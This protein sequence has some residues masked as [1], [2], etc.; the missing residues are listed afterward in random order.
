MYRALEL[1]E[2]GATAGSKTRAELDD[3]LG[4]SDLRAKIKALQ[5]FDTTG[6]AVQLNMATSI[7][8]N[9]LKAK[10]MNHTTNDHFAEAFE[11][12]QTYTPVD[13]WIERETHGMIKD[14]MGDD[15]IEDLTVALLVDAVYF[16]GSWM[17]EFDKDLN[18]DG[19]FY[20][21]DGS[22]TNATYMQSSRKM[23]ATKLS[24]LGD[25]SV[26]ALDYKN[27]EFSALF[28][29]PASDS[30]KSMQDAISG[31]NSQSL[32]KLIEETNDIQA[33]LKLPRFRL[34]FGPA[35]LKS[36]LQNMGMTTAFDNEIL[37]KFN[38][39][40][41]DKYLYIKD[42]FHG[43]SMEVNEEGTEAAASTV[44]VAT[45]RS[46]PRIQTM[47][48]VFNRPFIVVI[49]HQSSGVPL[50]IGKVEQP[51]FI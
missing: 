43:A 49:S 33:E 13:E 31:L 27:A 3:L 28:I 18:K 37:G 14:L 45:T 36:V 16:K 15:T 35:S 12:P 29:L 9:D 6:G 47:K 48:L 25:A 22:H 38:R 19:L 42:I 8:A 24:S 41:F 10:Y 5:R 46:R 1:V 4:P 2:D 44:V 23:K 26:V 11:L 50:F 40:T 17:Y 32:T 34:D 20:Y 7:W 51:E 30:E 21:R 39:M